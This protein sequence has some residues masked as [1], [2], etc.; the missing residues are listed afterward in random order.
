MAS[1]KVRL[2]A[3]GLGGWGHVLADGALK[4]GA[5]EIVSCFSRT[6][7]TRRA[8]AKK[9]GCRQANRLDDVLKDSEVEG[10][11]IATPHSTHAGII[12]EAASAG[13][14]VFVDKPLTLT[15]ADARR[16]IRETARAGVVLQVGHHRRRLGATRRIRGM[17]EQGALGMLHQLEANFSIP[18]WQNPKPGWRTDPA[19]R[20]AGGMTGQG[21]HMVDNFHYLAGPVKRLSAFSKKLLG[22]TSLNDVTSAIFEFE[23]GPLGYLG[24][25]LV[26]PKMINLS[27]FGT[28]GAAWSE[29]D[30]TRLYFQGRDENA[31]KELPV[32]AGD[33]VAEQ[34]KEFS[35]CIR[36]GGRPETGGPEGL[37]VVAVLEAIIESMNTGRAVEVAP[38]RG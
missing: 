23:S 33:P 15:V 3:V 18:N 8:F 36:E 11:L 10:V 13:K 35:R 7:E 38:F 31:R 6:Q 21:V 2:A 9:Y 30:G 24:T 16:S 37:E 14:H 17:I 20:P 12:C 26:I 29:E 28:D 5:C 4:S 34:L 27:A 22:R 25:T 1:G 32:E 19:E